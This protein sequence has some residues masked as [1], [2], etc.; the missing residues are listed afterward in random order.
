MQFGFDFSSI[1]SE[2]FYEKKLSHQKLT[3]I[4][5]KRAELT[6]DGN[7]VWSYV[8]I[9]DME[10]VGSCSMETDGISEALRNTAGIDYSVFFYET[11]PGTF[12]VS[13]RSKKKTD[14]SR[15]ASA[16]GGGGHIRAAGCSFDEKSPQEMIALIVQRITEQNYD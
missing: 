8:T 6:S 16:F 7:G 11:D 10:D 9:K 13:M 5:L 15:A 3:G 4:A 14:V 2:S 1:I 12:K